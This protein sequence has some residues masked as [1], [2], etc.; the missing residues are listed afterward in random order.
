[1]AGPCN[2]CQSRLVPN[3]P[4]KSFPRPEV[5]ACVAAPS[6]ER[7]ELLPSDAQCLWILRELRQRWLEDVR[8]PARQTPRPYNPGGGGPFHVD[9]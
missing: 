2:A 6:V 9:P 4:A 3:R 1:M 5:R 7:E 8:W